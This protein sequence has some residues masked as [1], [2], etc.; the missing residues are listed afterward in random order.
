MSNWI[1]KLGAKIKIRQTLSISVLSR[2]DESF[3][4]INEALKKDVE[5]INTEFYKNKPGLHLEIGDRWFQVNDDDKSHISHGEF[6]ND[7]LKLFIM[8]PD[9]EHLYLQPVFEQ[10]NGLLYK[11]G[12]ELMTPEKISQ[13]V[14]EPIVIANFHLEE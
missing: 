1:D 7:S 9:G 2:L 14:V 5:R 12:S 13:L 10:V 3:I 6:R 4:Y 8:L 11:H